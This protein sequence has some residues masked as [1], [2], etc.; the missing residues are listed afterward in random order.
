M[1]I[2][3]WWWDSRCQV[4]LKLGLTVRDEVNIWGGRGVGC[5][6]AEEELQSRSF[7]QLNREAEAE[8]KQ[9]K[10]CQHNLLQSEQS[11]QQTTF[12]TSE[13]TWWPLSHQPICTTKVQILNT[14]C[15]MYIW[16]LSSQ[17]LL[18]QFVFRILTYTLIQIF[19][20]SQYQPYD[21]VLKKF[22][23]PAL[24]KWWCE[25]STLFIYDETFILKNIKVYQIKWIFKL[26]YNALF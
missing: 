6:A 10:W 16:W 19:E 13:N 24:M 14:I 20:L 18:F 25:R 3:I 21:F 4:Q 7:D 8:I 5:I 23:E 2:S 17:R 26:C 22:S 11:E 9:T 15:S 1:E 12:K